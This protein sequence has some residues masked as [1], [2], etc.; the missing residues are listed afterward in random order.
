MLYYFTG[1]DR[2]GGKIL[3]TLMRRAGRFYAHLW[4]LLMSLTGLVG[5]SLFVKAVMG[6]LFV[7]FVYK[8]TRYGSSVDAMRQ[9]DLQT[10]LIL[11]VLAM[12]IYLIHWAFSYLIELPEERKGTVIT[13]VMNTFGLFVTSF[14]FYGSLILFVFELISGGRSGGTL[15]WVLGSFSFWLFY[16]LKVVW[17]VKNEV[18]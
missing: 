10:G 14:I 18:E 7:D 5:F 6:S 1:K 13:K 12:V 4:M 15:S 16:A 17:V 8:S 11:F 3:S 9:S 2:E